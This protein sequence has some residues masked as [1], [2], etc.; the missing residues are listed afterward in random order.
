MSPLDELAAGFLPLDAGGGFQIVATVT[1][2]TS[3]LAGELAR[4]GA[5]AFA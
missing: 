1:L 5:T 2:Q 3:A 4:A